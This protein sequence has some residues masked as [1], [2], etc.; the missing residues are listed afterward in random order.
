MSSAMKRTVGHR[1]IAAPPPPHYRAGRGRV[2]ADP[3]LPSSWGV[4][5]GQLRPEV[6][7]G[8][9]QR[10]EQLGMKGAPGAVDADRFVAAR[11]ESIGFHPAMSGIEDPIMGEAAGAESWHLDAPFAR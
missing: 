2:R 1:V 10:G 3:G 7:A 6:V 8:D 5:R 4:R 11:A 9:L